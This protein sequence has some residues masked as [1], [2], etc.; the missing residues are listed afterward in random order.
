[1]T[2]R[3]TW[4]VSVLLVLVLGI[5]VSLPSEIMTSRLG[6]Y[7]DHGERPTFNGNIIFNS[8]ATG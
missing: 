5:N 2:K 1:M 4:D 6:D 7:L 8:N 3:L